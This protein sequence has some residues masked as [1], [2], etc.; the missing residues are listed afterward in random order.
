M[1]LGFWD[2]VVIALYVAAM[3]G[4]GLLITSKIKEFK[5]YFLAGRAMTTP[6]LICTIVST[7]YELDVTFATSERGYYNGVVAWFWYSRPY[8]IAILMAAF[9]LTKRLRKQDYWSLP[10][11]LERSYGKPTRVIGALGCFVYSLPITAMAGLNA[12]FHTLGWQPEVAMFASVGVCA[13][14]TL[15]GGLWADALTDTFQFVLMC[16]TVAIAVPFALEMVGGFGFVDKLP[17]QHMTTTGGVSTWIILA[18]AASAFTVFVDP[19]FYQRI[20]AAKDSKSVKYAFLVGILLWASYDWLVTLIGMIARYAA[21]NGILQSDLEG[22]KALLVVCMK[23]LPAGL[24]GLFIAGILS[25]AMSSVD[26]YS[27]LASGN[28]VYDIYR[29]LSR[30]TIGDK[31]LMKLTRFGVF[32][33][34]L[35]GVGASLA[36]DKISDAW[37]FMAGVMVSIVF[38]PVMIALFGKPKRLTGLLAALFGFLALLA[39]HI[40]VHSAGTYDAEEETF[41]WKFGGF[42]IWRE[43]GVLFALPMSLAGAVV[44]Q[45][46]GRKN[47]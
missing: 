27:L 33:V 42:E 36:F 8:Y 6:L 47:D 45:I 38:V 35:I 15:M 28:L 13:L 2:W 19:A 31:T 1:I 3:I 37:T 30:K 22:K 14:Y 10:D 4:V 17:Q 44:G 23:T 43:Y 7:Y 46:F 39:F 18:W 11:I 32:A 26:S 25:A 34:M 41:I 16:V 29:P 20:F 12:M 24:K 21:D 9:L 40:V 5:D